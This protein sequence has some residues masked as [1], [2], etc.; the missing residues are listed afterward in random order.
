MSTPCGSVKYTPASLSTPSES[1]S[2]SRVV[3]GVQE[4]KYL[5]SRKQLDMGMFS[6]LLPFW[7]FFLTLPCGREMGN[8]DSQRES[9]A[10]PVP[11]SKIQSLKSSRCSLVL[12]LGRLASFSRL[13]P[14]PS[15][16]CTWYLAALVPGPNENW[17]NG[18][19]LNCSGRWLQDPNS[20]R[21]LWKKIM[22]YLR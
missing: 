13:V 2:I 6:L 15:I 7:V 9:Y 14:G 21:H 8:G 20:E 19:T 22:K 4:Q 18:P 5:K 1:P 3:W 16:I 10:A 12:V 11:I 17:A